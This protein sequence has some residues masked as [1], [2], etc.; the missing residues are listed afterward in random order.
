MATVSATAALMTMAKRDS[1]RNRGG[2]RGN[3]SVGGKG[4]D[5]SGNFGGKP[6]F[7]R[8]HHHFRRHRMDAGYHTS[9]LAIGWKVYF[10]L[11]LFNIM[12]NLVNNI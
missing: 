6:N 4:G 2:G 7:C 10:R 1:K 3:G 5:G 12:L 8:C 9:L 11:I